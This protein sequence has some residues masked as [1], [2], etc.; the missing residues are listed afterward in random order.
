MVSVDTAFNYVNAIINVFD[1]HLLTA[2]SIMIAFN[3]A[4]AVRHL[5]VSG[6]R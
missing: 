5:F 1:E 6:A 4:F 2:L 3:V